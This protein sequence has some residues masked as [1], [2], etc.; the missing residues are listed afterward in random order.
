MPAVPVITVTTPTDEP[1]RLRVTVNNGGSTIAHNDLWRFTASEYGGAFIL[2]SNTIAQDGHFDD[3]A[4]ASGRTYGYYVIAVD[5]SGI[6]AQSLTSLAS[7]LLG[8]ATLHAITKASPIA[9]ALVVGDGWQYFEME[10]G[11]P[12]IFEDGSLAQIEGSD[13]GYGLNGL[14]LYDQSHSRK[15]SVQSAL[16]MLSNRTRPTIGLSNIEDGIIDM[17]CIVSDSND[18]IRSIVE[19]IYNTRTTCCLR[20]GLG[21]K[22]FGRMSYREAPSGVS[23]VIDLSFEILDFQESLS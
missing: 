16:R 1:K 5:G 23:F 13:G 11:Q 21:D 15:Y 18:R 9:N 8:R 2:I 10:D 17:S 7:V 22:W 3:Y 4:V 6:T 19:A 20:T 12:F 14:G